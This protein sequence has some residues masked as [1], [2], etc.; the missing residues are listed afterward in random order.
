MSDLHEEFQRYLA[1]RE[2]YLARY[3]GK[4][5]VLKDGKLLGVYTSRLEAARDASTKAPLGTFLVQLVEED[6]GI[7][8]FHSRVGV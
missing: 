3:K 2:E 7:V 6:E 4:V 5:I 1:N 8:R